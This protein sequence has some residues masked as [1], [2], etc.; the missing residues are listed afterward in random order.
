[1]SVTQELPQYRQE[2]ERIDLAQELQLP[3]PLFARPLIAR[4]RF[5]FPAT[6]PASNQSTRLFGIVNDTKRL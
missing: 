2:P 5:R 3:A 6:S 4:K 1:M